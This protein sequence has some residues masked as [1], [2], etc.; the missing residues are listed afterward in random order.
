MSG[1]GIHPALQ[2]HVCFA[3]SRRF[4]G[5]ILVEEFGQQKSDRA[6]FTV[7]RAIAGLYGR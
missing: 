1:L 5:A 3:D 6:H 2:T 4:A 7:L